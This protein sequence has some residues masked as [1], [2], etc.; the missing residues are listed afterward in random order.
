MPTVD[1]RWCVII[2]I[3]AGLMAALLWA[4]GAVVARYLVHTDLP[5]DELTLLRY[6]GCFPLALAAVATLRRKALLDLP[7]LKIAVLVLLAGPLYQLIILLGYRH[8]TAGAGSLLV[9]GLLPVCGIGL[10]LLWPLRA[11][12][13]PLTAAKLIGAGFAAAGLVVLA[14]G[15]PAGSSFDLAGFAIFAIAALMW[16]LLNQLIRAWSVDP[17]K[18]TIALALWSPAFLPLWLLTRK[19]L[20]SLAV[21]SDGLLQI[22]YH[23]ILVAFVA[24]LLFFVAVRRLGAVDAGIIQTATPAITVAL[25]AIA[26]AEVPTAMQ[27]TGV[28]ITLVG[29]LLAI[30][31]LPNS[32][33]VGLGGMPTPL[34]VGAGRSQPTSG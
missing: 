15:G 1:N 20:P 26:L 34:A 23:G 32:S 27:V 33:Q 21:S 9:T 16:A 24:T 25:G 22:A 6:V 5:P 31:G 10:A 7:P 30:K 18:L 4:G 12:S 13:Q 29:L 2:G 28:A 17:L 11:Q 3:T 14:V 19:D 8:A